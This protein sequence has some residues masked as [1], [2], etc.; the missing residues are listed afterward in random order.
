[1]MLLHIER[2]AS[3]CQKHIQVQFILRH[4]SSTE[5][6]IFLSENRVD[7]VILAGHPPA[8]L[9]KKLYRREIPTVVIH[10]TAARTFCTCVSPDFKPATKEAVRRL[11]SLGHQRIG[12]VISNREF[13]T[14]ESRYQGYLEALRESG[15]EPRAEWVIDKK[16]S[17]IIGGREA[18][19]DYLKVGKLPT[20]IVF[21]N[22]WM[23]FGAAKELVKQGYRIPE[24][25]SLMG[26]DN[27]SICEEMDPPLTSVDGKLDT[28]V[29]IVF[30][31]LMRQM[32]GH[33]DVVERSL[34]GTLVWRETCGVVKEP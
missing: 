17:N 30:E 29:S 14:V 19:R 5:W 31:D 11:V 34:A 23:A 9:C 18:I 20:A 2:C 16:P 12:F 26:H 1:M 24:D 22:D 33:M 25:I 15:V 27:I 32:D 13:P 8:D 10:D 28:L 3:E 7:G 4:S 21:T 6:P